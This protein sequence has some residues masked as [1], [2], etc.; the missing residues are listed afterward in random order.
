MQ[1][2]DGV[3]T[4]WMKSA[5]QIGLIVRERLGLYYRIVDV[6]SL[7]VVQSKRIEID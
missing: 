6:P 4:I 1:G 3:D 7:K 5:T 2:I